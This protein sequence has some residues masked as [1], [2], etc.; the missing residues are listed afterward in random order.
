MRTVEV[1]NNAA[2]A[3]GIA[4]ATTSALL[5]HL[6]AAS[7]F[8]VTV[9]VCTARASAVALDVQRG[10]ERWTP[11]L[12]L[13]NLVY[14]TA[15]VMMALA[16]ILIVGDHATLGWQLLIAGGFGW[17]GPLALSAIGDQVKALIGRL[18]GKVDAGIIRPAPGP[19]PA[20]IQNP[21]QEAR[22][23]REVIDDLDRDNAQSDDRTGSADRNVDPAAPRP[24]LPFPPS[25]T[26]NAI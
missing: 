19:A 7:I 5:G 24:R 23:M 1:A 20:P 22:Q 3:G 13:F 16:V 14:M 11:T 18:F 26:G 4:G 9:A 8:L 17:L 12:A 10:A 21:E 6:D 25:K 2:Q 15:L